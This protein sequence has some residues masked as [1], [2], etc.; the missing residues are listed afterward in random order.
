MRWNSVVC[1]LRTRTG[2]LQ[3][4]DNDEAGVIDIVGTFAAHVRV[5]RA[6]T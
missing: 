5:V 6:H 2:I 4:E 1:R 3:T